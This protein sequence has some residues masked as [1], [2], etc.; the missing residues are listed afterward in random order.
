[1]ARL[2]LVLRADAVEHPLPPRS[3][4]KPGRGPIDDRLLGGH[5]RQDDGDRVPA[6]TETGQFYSPLRKPYEQ[7][8][9]TAGVSRRSHCRQGFYDPCLSDVPAPI[10]SD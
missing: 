8:F 2:P 4:P 3:R 9:G 10:G 6:G 7:D 5:E 1:M